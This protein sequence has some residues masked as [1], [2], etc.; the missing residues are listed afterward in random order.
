MSNQCNTCCTQ[1]Q[2]EETLVRFASAKLKVCG[3]KLGRFPQI[4][5]FINDEKADR[6]FKNMNVEYARGAS[7]TLILLDAEGTEVETLSL[8]KWDTDT[9]KEYLREHLV[10]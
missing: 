6:Q 5:A 8:E 10:L 1:E 9:V 3:W 4:K 7:P 2:V